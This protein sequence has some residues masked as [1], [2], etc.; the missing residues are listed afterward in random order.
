MFLS[1]TIL[2]SAWDAD[3]PESVKEYIHYVA[4]KEGVN[5]G[6]AL[7]IAHCESGITAGAIHQSPKEYSVGVF[8]INLKAHPYITREQALNPFFN[9]GWAIDRM[10]EGKWSWWSCF[11]LV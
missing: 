2:A 11:R 6:W 10:R 9:I 3:N 1:F 5:V 8:Q 7:T 4:S